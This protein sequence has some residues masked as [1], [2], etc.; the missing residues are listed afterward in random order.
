MRSQVSIV[1]IRAAEIQAG[2]VVNRRGPER[3]DWI[4]VERLEQLY[5]GTYV[6][7]DEAGRD[8]FTAKSY[9]LVWLQTLLPLQTNSHI[10]VDF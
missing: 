5:D 2:D 9:D 8:S 6:V 1:Q 3:T 7:H 4:E 10:P